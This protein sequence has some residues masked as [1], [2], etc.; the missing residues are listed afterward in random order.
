M[1][2]RTNELL[3][4][5]NNI[6]KNYQ[7]GDKELQVLSNI[8][9]QV[10]RGDFLII[11]GSSGSGKTTL[12]NCL[13][14][15]EPPSHGRVLFAGA[16][17]TAMSDNELAD[18]RAEHISYIFQSYNLISS[19]TVYENII[20]PL[21][22]RGEDVREKEHSIRKLMDRLNILEYIDAF[23][24]QLSGGQKQR[25][26]TV[27]AI[28]SGTDILI[29]DEPTGALDSA[30]SD[31]LMEFFVELNAN[32]NT[33]IIMVTHDP[34]AARYGDRVIFLKDGVIGRE[35]IRLN[36]QSPKSYLDE[37]YDHVQASEV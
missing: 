15:I 21:Q 37:I 28:I 27:R 9:L 24:D 4:V 17:L 30:N 36:G 29:A 10:N 32:F 19:L 1:R 3:L 14:M 34:L 6:S 16:D 33:T 20:L 2:R 31:N 13:S 26:A 23:P 18:F 5:A 35:I 8:D 25:V 12:L 7:Q 11:M 22:I